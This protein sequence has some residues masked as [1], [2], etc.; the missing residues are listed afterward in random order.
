V[1]IGRSCAGKARVRLG[2]RVHNDVCVCMQ[3]MVKDATTGQ[4][5]EK[6]PWEVLQ[7]PSSDAMRRAVKSGREAVRRL[8]QKSAEP[9]AGTD[10]ECF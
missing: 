10:V 9:E 6:W 1:L 7:Y 3:V 2:K 5:R 8:K 4:E